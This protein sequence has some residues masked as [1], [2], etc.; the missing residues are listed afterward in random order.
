VYE[1]ALEMS[2][3]RVF[4]NPEVAD[5]APSWATQLARERQPEEN[6]FNGGRWV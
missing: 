3:L 6:D 2:H 5:L 4:P 1:K